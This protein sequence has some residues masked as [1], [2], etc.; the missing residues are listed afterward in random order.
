M[1]PIKIGPNRSQEIDVG[2]WILIIPDTGRQYMVKVTS[3]KDGGRRIQC[4]YGGDRG[5][6]TFSKDELEEWYLEGNVIINPNTH[7]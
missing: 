2:D 1:T 3:I 6:K 5:N 4:V 7:G